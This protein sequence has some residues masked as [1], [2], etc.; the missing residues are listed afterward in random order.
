MEKMLQQKRWKK[1]NG[2]NQ[3]KLL[4]FIPYQGYI[5]VQFKMKR[6]YKL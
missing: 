5:K 1:Y 6:E 3:I 2:K 4:I